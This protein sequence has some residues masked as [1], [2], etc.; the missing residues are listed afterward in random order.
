[1]KHDFK[2][3]QNKCGPSMNK[4]T[5]IINMVQKTKWQYLFFFITVL[6]YHDAVLFMSI[7]PDCIAWVSTRK[8]NKHTLPIW[9]KVETFEWK[10]FLEFTFCVFH[11]L[12]HRGVKLL[13]ICPINS[14]NKCWHLFQSSGI[15]TWFSVPYFSWRLRKV[16][17]CRSYGSPNCW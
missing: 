7:H 5:L 4:N 9:C 11:R 14:G 16:D 3:Q 17:S 12:P 1:M 10:I 6:P 8:Y 15:W 13:T 2:S